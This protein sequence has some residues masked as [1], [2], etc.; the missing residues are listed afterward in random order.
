M[1][2]IKVN[3]DKISDFDLKLAQN[4]HIIALI[5]EIIALSLEERAQQYKALQE[6]IQQGKASLFE[7]RVH[8]KLLERRTAEWI[9][10]I[11]K[12]LP[13]IDWL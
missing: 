12:N 11:H 9:R 6:K 13:A 1:K 4:P 7:E 8:I 3:L 2:R 5:D 10:L